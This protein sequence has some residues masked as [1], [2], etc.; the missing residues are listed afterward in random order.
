VITSTEVV[1]AVYRPKPGRENDFFSLL[2][3][4]VATLREQGLV[5][6]RPVILLKAR[7]GYFIEIFEWKSATAATSAHENPAVQEIWSKLELATDF[8]NLAA[9]EECRQPFPH[10]EVIVGAG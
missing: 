6:E 4:H 10:F 1:I 8:M 5:T 7:N 9:L 3:N 2:S